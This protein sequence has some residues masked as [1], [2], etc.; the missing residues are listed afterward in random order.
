MAT[1]TIS[2]D[3]ATTRRVAV[4]AAALGMSSHAF[5]LASIDSALHKLADRD[6]LLGAALAHV[7]SERIQR[8]NLTD[9]V[10]I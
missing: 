10:S 2:P 5:I 3:D 1:R 8:V 7:G 4:A 9:T 6:S